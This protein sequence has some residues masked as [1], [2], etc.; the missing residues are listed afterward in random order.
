MLCTDLS[1]IK[2]TGKRFTA[3]PLR[4]KRWSCEVCREGNARRVRAIVCDG[5]PTTFITLTIRADYGTLGEQA[6]RLV[7]AWRMIRQRWAREH[8]GQKIPFIAVFERHP[9]SGRPHLHILCR[10]PYIPQRWI[11][12]RMR[13]L[14][15]SPVCD[16]RAVKSRRHAARYLSKYLAKGPHRF[17]GCK[18]YWRS[19]DWSR[20]ADERPPF[21]P[22]KSTHV[23]PMSFDALSQRGARFGSLW[24]EDVR[25]RTFVLDF[26]QGVILRC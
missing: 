22:S 14:A 3:E 12:G 4:C 13:E 16:I 26:W 10:A 15:G 11:S 20:R 21:D 1:K 19:Q 23:I 25:H 17:L 9:S 7:T 8:H 6:G 24:V 5:A 18:R 2:I